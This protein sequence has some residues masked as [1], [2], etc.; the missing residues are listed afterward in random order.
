MWQEDMR[1]GEVGGT[2]TGLGCRLVTTELVRPPSL[3][4]T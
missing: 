3:L 2:W 4:A 1:C